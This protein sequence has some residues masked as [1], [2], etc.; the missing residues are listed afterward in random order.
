MKV[1]LKESSKFDDLQSIKRR[2]YGYL[3][4]T[5]I[6]ALAF[7]LTVPIAISHFIRYCL[8]KFKFSDKIVIE[9]NDVKNADITMAKIIV[10]LLERLNV[11]KQGVPPVDDMDVPDAIMDIGVKFHGIDVSRSFKWEY[12]M[13]RMIISF[14]YVSNELAVTSCEEGLGDIRIPDVLK[15]HTEL[16]HEEMDTL[17]SLEETHGKIKM[18]DYYEFMEVDPNNIE[19]VVQEGLDLFSKYYLRLWT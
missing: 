15:I 1:R 8:H 3:D 9:S 2:Y 11:E 12:V 4:D 6:R 10:P 13:T 17:K 19:R 18:E 5:N 7:M 14:K 16:I